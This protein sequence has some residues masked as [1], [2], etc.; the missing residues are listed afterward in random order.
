MKILQTFVNQQLAT[1][2]CINQI[3]IDRHISH[4]KSTWYRTEWNKTM[5]LLFYHSSTPSYTF[6]N[7]TI[8]LYK[9]VKICLQ[10]SHTKESSYIHCIREKFTCMIVVPLHSSM[11]FKRTTEKKKIHTHTQPCSIYLYSL[12]FSS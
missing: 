12:T 4:M 5:Y 8:N 7:P 9:F 11:K 3:P 1:D 2:R 6:L 10:H